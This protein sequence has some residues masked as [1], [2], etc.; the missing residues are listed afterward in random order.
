MK[1]TPAAGRRLRHS[2]P[3]SFGACIDVITQ[4]FP[5][6]FLLS[7]VYAYF[8]FMNQ[9]MSAFFLYVFHVAACFLVICISAARRLL[10]GRPVFFN[11]S[12]VRKEW[13]VGAPVRYK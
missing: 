3:P 11:F 10:S 12:T 7:L 2:A 6:I 4:F 13:R 9:F 1:K 5:L 8:I